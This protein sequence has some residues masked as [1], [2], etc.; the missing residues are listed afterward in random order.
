[1]K[2]PLYDALCA[3]SR[4]DA[5]RMHMPGHK[6]KAMAEEFSVA[7]I[8]YTEI[9]P[10]GNLYTGEGPIAEAEHL[11]AQCWGAAH[12]FFLTGGSSQGVKAGLSLLCAP[13]DTILLDRNAHKSFFSAM[14]L[15]DLS[16]VYLAAPTPAYVENCL[17]GHPQLKTVCITSPTYYGVIAPVAEIA[18][19]CKKYGAKLL[20]DEAHGAHFPFV[21][22]GACAAGRG[23][24]VSI[25][26]AHKTLPALGSSALLF[27]DDSFPEEDVR[28]K[29]ALFGTS[30]P[31]YAL[32]ASID[33]ARAYLEGE[34]GAEYCRAA[35]AVAALREEINGR[36]VFHALC[37]KD[38]HPLD[39][40]RLTVYTACGGLRGT[41][42]ARFLQEKRQ[43]FPEMDDREH[44]VFI[45]TGSDT[46]EDISRLGR[47]LEEM[48]ALA[49]AKA[50]L[51]PC[52]A[53]PEAQRV[54]PIRAALFSP[55][56]RRALKDCVGRVSAVSIAPYPPGVP[57]VAPGERIGAEI[58]EYLRAIGY[59][60]DEIV[61]LVK[62]ERKGADAHGTK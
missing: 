11:A 44:V 50:P 57:V 45:I 26:S 6:G 5:L 17:R 21:G 36:G 28:E 14:A 12:A 48:E 15:L 61:A 39:P 3:L 20:V 32:M 43:I 8:D 47:A 51:P 25:S 38:G 37:E 24:A 16:P 54:L 34:G 49:E 60:L 62:E 4:Q 40:T 13:G 52:P 30:S 33:W 19:V 31:S 56:E 55:R 59:D 27:T 18:A 41:E 10:T 29:T 35:K 22:L 42:A 2:A 9:P 23:A 53:V 46:A 1:M 58:L 7:A